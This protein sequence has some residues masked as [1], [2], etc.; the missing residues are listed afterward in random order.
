[1]KVNIPN[2]QICRQA[3]PALRGYMYQVYRSLE[4][5]LSLNN[6]HSLLL[7]VAEDFAVLANQALKATQV[8]DTASSGSVTLRTEAIKA[9][10]NFF[11]QF[12]AANPSKEVRL[13]FLTTSSIGREQGVKFPEGEPGLGYWRVASRHGADVRI[14][15]SFLASLKISEDL[16]QFLRT[17][18]DSEIQDRLLRRIQ[19]ECG[20]AALDQVDKQV[21][22]RLVYIGEDTQSFEPSDVVSPHFHFENTAATFC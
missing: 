2:S 7:E 16:E 11:W 4:A 8:K 13:V 18:T 22:D 9:A 17:A 10:I 20:A 5:W 14:L 19:W 1:M 3:I 12:Q 21:R 15:S 6:T